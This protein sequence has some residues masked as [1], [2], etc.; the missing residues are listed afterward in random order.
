MDV[1]IDWTAID[2]N[3]IKVSGGTSK[4]TQNTDTYT[5]HI[6][7]PING[8]GDYVFT[9]NVTSSAGYKATTQQPFTVTQEDVASTRSFVVG[10]EILT[11]IM[12]VGVAFAVRVLS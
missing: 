6:I 1:T 5:A 12:I 3:N 8:A 7:I 10:L 11:V 9:A 2:A 4:F